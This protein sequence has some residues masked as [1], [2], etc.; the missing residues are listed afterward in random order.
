MGYGPM[1]LVGPFAEERLLMG[2][3]QSLYMDVIV[4]AH[5]NYVWC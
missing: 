2:P 4:S 5:F 1:I 3:A